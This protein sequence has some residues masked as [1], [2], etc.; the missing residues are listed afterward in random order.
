MLCVTKFDGYDGGSSSE[1]CPM[2]KL[3]IAAS[4]F[5]LPYP[6]LAADVKMTGEEIGVALRDHTL[7]GTGE[8]GKPWSQI[9]QKTGVTYYS[10]GTAQSQ[11]LWEVRGDQYCSQ[12]PPNESWACYDIM[13]DGTT[14]SFVSASGKRSSGTLQN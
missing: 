2:R 1:T 14:Y 10:V 9:F 4:L 11:G 7:Q 12:W 5:L 8:D 13:R 3:L 6:A